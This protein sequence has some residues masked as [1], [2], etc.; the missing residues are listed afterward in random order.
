MLPR[1]EVHEA[2]DSAAHTNDAP[3]LNVVEEKLGRIAGGGRLLGGEQALLADRHLEESVPIR[4]GYN[5][6][7]HA[8][9]LSLTLVL[10]KPEAIC[11]TNIKRCFTFVP[12]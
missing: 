9:R 4:A 10:C 2:I 7:C 3:A 5:R 11:C 12:F 6:L 8:Q 1:G